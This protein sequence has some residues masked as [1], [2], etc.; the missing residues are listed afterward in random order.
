MFLNT[1]I[2]FF[3]V[4]YTGDLHFQDD[5]EVRFHDASPPA[6]CARFLYQLAIGETESLGGVIGTPFAADRQAICMSEQKAIEALKAF[7][8]RHDLRGLKIHSKEWN[9]HAHKIYYPAASGFDKNFLAG[10]P[11][12]RYFQ[13]FTYATNAGTLQLWAA[14]DEVHGASWKV[15]YI[16]I[17]KVA[18][19]LPG[20]TS[21]LIGPGDGWHEMN[22]VTGPPARP[23]P[24]TEPARRPAVRQSR[25]VNH[26]N[27]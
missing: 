21:R 17:D 13:R 23:E 3:G 25:A 9:G 2:P 15:Y 20:P 14:P 26:M 4:Q 1:K 10:A 11:V 6:V 16:S 22:E 27:G 18:A 7:T 24:V 5:I 8:Q 12:E 19:N